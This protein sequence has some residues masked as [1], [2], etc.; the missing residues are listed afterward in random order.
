MIWVLKYGKKA[1]LSQRSIFTM[2]LQ[3]SLKAMLLIGY[4]WAIEAHWNNASDWHGEYRVTL[5][6]SSHTRLL[7][8]G[9][10]YPATKSTE[11]HIIMVKRLILVG[12]FE[13]LHVWK[14][15][16]SISDQ[17]EITINRRLIFLGHANWLFVFVIHHIRAAVISL[18]MEYIH[19]LSL[20]CAFRNWS[21]IFSLTPIPLNDA[22]WP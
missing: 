12:T 8:A 17:Y 15:S 3:M 16:V 4:Q 1:V 13:R 9:H 2:N 21:L 18:F 14:S 20:H 10:M 6:P 5:P 22:K 19:P 11:Q 7:N